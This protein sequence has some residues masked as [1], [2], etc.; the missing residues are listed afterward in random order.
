MS[1]VVCTASFTFTVDLA[2][3]YIGDEIGF[4]MQL[5]FIQS[6]FIT[7]WSVS[8]AEVRKAE[9]HSKIVPEVP[10]KFS[11]FQVILRK[12]SKTH[13]EYHAVSQDPLCYLPAQ[14]YLC[15]VL[16]S[17]NQGL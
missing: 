9:A 3:C 17:E 13:V 5:W 8:Q 6:A 15:F 10:F 12:Y 11:A 4:L 7:I 16:K 14:H 1:I 2:T